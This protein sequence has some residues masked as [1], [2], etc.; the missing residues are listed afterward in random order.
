[1]DK[2]KNKGTKENKKNI[3][4]GVSSFI[5]GAQCHGTGDGNR[6]GIMGEL[7]P[8]VKTLESYQCNVSSTYFL[9][10]FLSVLKH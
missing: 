10:W 6:R 4:A 5:G 7:G 2:R 8:R 9:R 3:L 1:M